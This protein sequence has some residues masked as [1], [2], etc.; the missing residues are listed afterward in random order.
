MPISKYG[1][2]GVEAGVAA[3]VKA[4][5]HAE[6]VLVLQKVCMTKPLGKNKSDTIKFRTP[7]PFAKATTPLVEGVTPTTK[8]MQYT[9]VTA[10][11]KQYGN[12]AELTDKIEDLSEDP[13]LM[14]SSELMGENAGGTMEAVLYGTMKGGTNVFYGAVADAA[15]TD[16]N[17][18]VSVVRLR[19][20]V[21]SLKGQK[22][23]PITKILDGSPKYG[24]KSV[25]A[26]YVAFCH[27]DLENDIRNLTG[28]TSVAD[29]GNRKP[30]CNEEFGSLE[31][32]RFITSPELDPFTDSGSA[33][34]NG[35]VTSGTKV[36]V[37]PIIIVAQDAVACIP[38]KGQG[39]IHP[40]VINPGTVDKSDPLGQRG[41]V[42]WKAWF[43]SL[44]TN[45]AW[46]ARLEVGAT[47]I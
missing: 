37:Y 16:V 31:N 40:T 12:L 20:V 47:D 32:I 14:E 28:F 39:A 35:M 44:I 2:I 41:Y 34:L 23:K 4:L 33:T 22:G 25:E 10:T 19:A 1:D 13:V 46:V 42:G 7:V 43:A 11:V 21:K 29:Y 3:E 18:P 8:Q 15:R 27:T 36:D 9:R 6:N 30:I 17:D 38:L 5:K 24:S 45:Q 26:A